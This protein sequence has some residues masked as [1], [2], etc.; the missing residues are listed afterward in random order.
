MPEI[1]RT[2][3]GLFATSCEFA[4]QWAKALKR[5]CDE[6][7]ML[8]IRRRPPLRSLQL[9]LVRVRVRVPEIG[10][11]RLDNRNRCSVGT[12]GVRCVRNLVF[13]SHLHEAKVLAT[14]ATRLGSVIHGWQ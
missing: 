11:D 14:V 13:G 6:R 3:R 9:R 5:V 4:G 8:S 7:H 2:K 12:G 10:L 1:D